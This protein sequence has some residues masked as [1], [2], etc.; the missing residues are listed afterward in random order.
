MVAPVLDNEAYLFIRSLKPKYWLGMLAAID[1][2]L[3]A[4]ARLP[5]NRGGDV[6]FMRFLIATRAYLLG[7]GKQR[8]GGMDDRQFLFLKPLCAHLV[9][10]GR[11]SPDCEALFDG[12]EPWTPRPADPTVTERKTR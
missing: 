6:E 1:A 11:F 5:A 4:L 3:L 10:R 12:L 7:N 2:E 9:A 8:P